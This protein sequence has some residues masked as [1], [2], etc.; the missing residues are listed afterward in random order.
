MARMAV[1]LAFILSLAGVA[2]GGEKSSLLPDIPKATG[3]AHAEGNAF[4]RRNHMDMMQL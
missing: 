4:W 1:L 3:K 2:Q